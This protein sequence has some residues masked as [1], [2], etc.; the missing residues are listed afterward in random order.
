M[1]NKNYKIISL[2]CLLIC[3]LVWIPNI[4]FQVAS[5][6]YLVT[7]ILAP[8]GIVFAALIR[9]YWVIVA[10]TLMFFSFF[11]FMYVG[12]FANSN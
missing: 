2:V 5:P 6:L 10:N 4:V 9:K 7:F 8:V 3:I 11:I 12:Y 1:H